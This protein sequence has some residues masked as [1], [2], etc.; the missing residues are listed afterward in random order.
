V[1]RVSGEA[2]LEPY[3]RSGQGDTDSVLRRMDTYGP[4]GGGGGGRRED[5]QRPRPSGGKGYRGN[6]YNSSNP[7]TGYNKPG[8]PCYKKMLS[9]R[10]VCVIHQSWL[11]DDSLPQCHF[12]HEDDACMEGLL[13]LTQQALAS[14]L[15]KRAQEQRRVAG[16]LVFNDRLTVDPQY[17]P[18]QSTKP[19]TQ[20]TPPEERVVQPPPQQQTPARI[21][22]KRVDFEER[23]PDRGVV[24]T[25]AQAR[26]TV[27]SPAPAPARPTEAQ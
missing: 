18:P 12:N 11:Q 10:A 4:G 9:N 15:F 19:S 14:P 27:H 24:R 17:Q 2:S 23:G 7:G 22:Q 21:L 20:L 16:T 13:L 1:Q 5:Y 3:A 8:Y 26:M 6:A 25:D